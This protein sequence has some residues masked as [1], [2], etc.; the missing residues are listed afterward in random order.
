MKLLLYKIVL[1]ILSACIVVGLGD[2]V[3]AGVIRISLKTTLSI[4]NGVI[5]T[6]IVATNTGTD[7][8]HRLRGVLHIFD[9]TIISDKIDR[10]GV[11]KSHAFD[12]NIDLPKDKKGIYPF[13]GEV[14][15]HD[16]NQH[17]FSALSAETFKVKSRLFKEVKGT[18]T[19]P[20]VKRK[21]KLEIRVITNPFANPLNLKA[22]LYLP[23]ALSAS[24]SKQEIFIASGEGK[25]F[26]F[27]LN[28][29]FG[30]GGAKYPA[31]CTLEYNVNGHHQTILIRS[32]IRIQ[33]AENWFIATKW[34][35]LAGLPVLLVGWIGIGVWAKGNDNFEF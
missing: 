2:N 19:N 20:T 27:D 8:A 10:L 15:F 21:G 35:W 13:I 1:F 4:R 9:R 34:F 30:A 24:E 5:Q 7:A 17:P 28:N 18:A 22:T 33:E 29:R 14:R 32:V 26:S 31:F 11:Q 3:S 25:D 23:Y 6:K 12:I 16:A